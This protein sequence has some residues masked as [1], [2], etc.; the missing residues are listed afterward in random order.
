MSCPELEKENLLTTVFK[1]EELEF[2]HR[3][4]NKL[5]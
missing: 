4:P 3:G 5:F 2:T 1:P